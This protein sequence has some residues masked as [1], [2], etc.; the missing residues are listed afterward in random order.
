LALMDNMW[1]RLRSSRRLAL[2]VAAASLGASSCRRHTTLIEADTTGVEVTIHYDPGLNLTSLQISGMV[3]DQ[4]AFPT[5]SLPNPPRALTSGQET[6]AVLVPDSLAGMTVLLR[7]DGLAADKVMGSDQQAVA[8]Q[9]GQLVPLTLTLGDPAICGDGVLRAGI[10]ECDDGNTTSDDGCSSACRREGA[11]A[12]NAT[13]C[14]NGCCATGM[15]TTP[16]TTVCGSGGATC[17]KCDPLTSD[18]CGAGG[19]CAC[20]PGPQCLAGQHCVAGACTCDGTSC[21]S[22]CCSGNVCM[23]GTADTAC[24]KG[25][26][27]CQSCATGGCSKGVCNNCNPSNCG[28]GCCSGSTCYPRSLSTCGTGA[29]ACNACDATKADTCSTSG[30]CACGSGPPCG[31]GQRCL[32]GACV[33][34]ATSCATG[35]CSGN[36][37][38]S[39]TL[40]TCGAKGGA[41]NACDPTKADHCAADGSCACGLTAACAGGQRCDKGLCTCD[42]T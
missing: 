42:A 38:N 34:D 29:A 10:E 13:T 17:L 7:I 14:P 9:L 8:V 1:T 11:D 40:A 21:A 26:L 31:S 35:C 23:P 15:C 16:S 6:A 39:P 33:C 30:A 19:S 28:S 41:C 18:G 4:L 32:S 3:G 37:C 25:G 24:G 27:A 22:G 2:A 12:C 36:V 5:G 20:G